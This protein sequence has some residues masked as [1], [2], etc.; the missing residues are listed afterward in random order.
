MDKSKILEEI[1]T[2]KYLDATDWNHLGIEEQN[3]KSK[4]IVLQSKLN[5]APY[6]RKLMDSFIKAKKEWSIINDV[7]KAY[8][9]LRHLRIELAKLERI[10]ILKLNPDL[11]IP[12]PDDQGPDLKPKP[13]KNGQ[14]NL[15]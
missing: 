7:V 15:F 1:K 11:T 2:L 10:D 3:L 4:A 14:L 9:R 6:D 13:G 5:K 12:K 8:I